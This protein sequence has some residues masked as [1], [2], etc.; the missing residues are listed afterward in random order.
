MDMD[1]KFIEETIPEMATVYVLGFAKPQRQER[2][3]LRHRAAMKLRDLK[4]DS[5]RLMKYDL[6]MDGKIDEQEWELARREMEQE[7]LAD[8]LMEQ[9]DSGPQVVV[10][11]ARHS[12]LPFV[13]AE[14]QEP[15]LARSFI[16]KSR[17]WTAACVVLVLIGVLSLLTDY[18]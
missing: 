7:A 18:S 12:R 11:R 14:D 1:E 3:P 10:G 2:A 9:K 4:K 16:W 8:V 15:E 5:V 13:V 17:L 6:N